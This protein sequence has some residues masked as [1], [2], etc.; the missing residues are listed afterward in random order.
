MRWPKVVR[1]RDKPKLDVEERYDIYLLVPLFADHPP[2]LCEM[3]IGN[4]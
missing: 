2:S 4:A 3:C 1:G